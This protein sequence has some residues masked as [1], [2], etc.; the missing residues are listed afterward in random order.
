MITT[1]TLADIAKTLSKISDKDIIG[2]NLIP[3]QKIY[4]FFLSKSS[5]EHFSLR[6]LM[7]LLPYHGD[8]SGQRT[9]L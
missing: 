5:S 2:R 8:I 7:P 4:I 6:R 3:V 9:K 1:Y